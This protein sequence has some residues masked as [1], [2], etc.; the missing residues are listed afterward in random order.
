ME[1][2]S[3]DGSYKVNDEILCKIKDLF[4]AD[5]ADD[6]ETKQTISKVYNEYGYTADTHTAVAINVYDKYI[7]DTGD[8]TKTV[9]A[10]TANPYK[11]NE[12]VIGAIAGDGECEGLDEFKLLDKLCDISKLEIPDSLS[13]LKVKP[14]RFDVVCNKEDMKDIATDFLVNKLK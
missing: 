8:A 10:S 6:C 3:K 2:L 13:Q 5:C 12:S 11:F 4:Y 7:M 9:I 14:V 1:K